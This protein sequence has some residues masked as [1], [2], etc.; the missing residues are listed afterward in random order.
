M[1]GFC[2]Q[3]RCHLNGLNTILAPRHPAAGVA[4]IFLDGDDLFRGL[5]GQESELYLGH[6]AA[7]AHFPPFD[8]EMRELIDL[9]LR[10]IQHL[11][12]ELGEVFV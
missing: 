8:G 1:D 12:S 3:P 4:Q 9:R 6:C 5:F 2:E 10:L 11:A 7:P